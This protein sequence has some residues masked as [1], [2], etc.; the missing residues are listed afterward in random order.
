MADMAQR[1]ASLSPAQR[2]LLEQ[3][4]RAQPQV[5]QP[6]AVIGMSCRLPGASNPDEFWSLIHE[7][8]SAVTEIPAERWDANAFYDADYEALGKMATRWCAL[9]D[10][11]D[12]F[13]SLFFGIAPREAS[14]MDPQQRLLLESA[15]EA[16]E[17]A[18]IA[19]DQ[20]SGTTTGVFVGIGGTDYSKL[21]YQHANFYESI[22][23]HTGTGNALSIAANRVSY[24]LDLRGPSVAV[25]TACSSGLVALH[26]AVQALRSGECDA[27]L[28]GATNMILS[29]EVTI[30][31]SKARMLSPTGHCRPFD[32]EADGYVRGEGCAFVLLKR[33]TDAV[34]DGDNILGVIRGTAVNQDGRTSGITAPNSLSQEACI[35]TALAAAGLRPEDISYIEA[36]G[37]GT[38]LGDPIEFQSLAKLF[39]ATEPK[40]PTCFVTSVKANIGH[41]ETVSGIAGFIKVLLML[42]HGRIPKQAGL[43]QLN[44]SISLSG[45]RLQIP[46]QE[47]DWPSD[48]PRIAGISSFGFGGTNTH[49]VVESATPVQ[50]RAASDNPPPYH[51]LVISAKNRAALHDLAVLYRERL[52]SM[53]DDHLADFCYSANTGRT[54]FNHRLAMSADTRVTL[55]ERLTTAIEGKKHAQVHTGELRLAGRP[56]VA[57]LFTGQG[58]QYAGMGK[59]LYTH[60]PV[61]REIVDKC[62]AILAPVL[63]K[64][65]RE[66]MLEDPESLIDETAYT[67]PALFVIEYAL[68]KLWQSWGVEPTALL[69]H[70]VGE[71]VAACLAGVFSLEAGLLLIAKRATLMQAMPPNGMMAVIFAGRDQVEKVLEPYAARV[72]VAT[73][74]GPENNVISGST[75]LVEKAVAE[76]EKLGIGTQKLRVSHAF[77][78]P[79]MDPMLDEFEKFAEQFEF[80]RPRIPI[81]ANRT[82]RLTDTAEFNAAYWRDHLRNCVEFADGIA[83]L[84]EAGVDAFLEVGPAASLVGM[85]KR[86]APDSKALWLTSLR[87]NRDDF[88]TLLSA[89]CDLYVLG[90]RI[91]WSSFESPWAHHRLPLPNYPF[92]RSRHWYVGDGSGSVARGPSLHPLLGC[93]IGTALKSRIFEG[94]LSGD[95]PRYLRDHVVQ[96]GVVVPAAAYLEQ[97]LA[98]G[99]LTFGAGHHAVE[100]LAIQQGLFLPAEGARVVETVVGGESSGRAAFE[101][102]SAD[103][104]VDSGEAKW[105]LHGTGTIAHESTCKPEPLP[106]LPDRDAFRSAAIHVMSHDEIYEMF[107]TRALHYGPCFRV[108]SEVARNRDEA[109]ASLDLNEIVKAKLGDYTVHPAVGDAMLQLMAGVIPLEENLEHAPYTYIPMRVRSFQAFRPVEEQ[110]WL[111]ARRTSADT[112]HPETVEADVYLLTEDNQPV[113]AAR[114]VVVQRIGRSIQEGPAEES[115]HWLYEIAWREAEVQAANL[116][117]AAAQTAQDAVL[118]LGKMDG[119]GGQIA[120]VVR[121]AG[122]RALVAEPGKAFAGITTEQGI[123]RCQVSLIDDVAYAQLLDAAVDA[124]GNTW[125]VVHAFALDAPSLTTELQSVTDATDCGT[126]SALRLM[127]QLTRCRKIKRAHVCFLTRGGQQVQATDHVAVQQSALWGFGRVAAI[128]APDA[129]CRIMDLDPAADL[130][131][132]AMQVFHEISSSTEENQVAYRSG[133]RYVARLVEIADDIATVGEPGAMQVPDSANYRLRI[134][135]A[136]SFDGLYYEPFSVPEPP[137]GKVEIEVRA[138]GLNFSDV[139]KAMGLYPGITDA[140]VPLGIECA[141]IIRAVGKGVTRFKVGDEVMGVAPYSF[142]SRTVTADYALVH[143]P[144]TMDF[145]EAATIPITFLTAYYALV[146]LA[147]LQKGERVLIHAGAGGVGLAAIQIAQ[148]IGA[149]IF[150]TAGSEEKRDFVRSLGVPHVMSSRTLDF[151]DQIR[152]ITDRQGVDVVLNSLPGDFIDKSLEC[153]RAYGRFLE[154]GKTDI[155]SNTKIGLLPFQDNLSYFA[156]DLDRMLRQRG[157]YIQEM[158]IEMMKYFEDGRYRPLPFTQFATTDTVNAFR[159]MAQRKNIGKVVV[160]MQAARSPREEEAAGRALREDA[161][162]V[163]TGG[164]GALGLQVARQLVDDGARHIALLGRRAPS[165]E[166]RRAIEHAEKSGAKVAV[167]QGDVADRASLEAALRQIPTTFPDVRGIVHAA[168]V[169]ADGMMFD[170]D[171]PQWYQPLKPKIDGTW[172]LHEATKDLDLDFFVMFSSVAC[173]LG[174]PGQS[175]YAAGNAFL[176]GMV[177]YRQNQGLPATSINWGPWADSGMAAEAGRDSQLAGRGM[178]L[179]PSDKSLQLLSQF[180]ASRAPR[181]VVM[182]VDWAELVRAMG[183]K[184]S[185]LLREVASGAEGAGEEASA[186]DRAYRQTLLELPVA[187][188][189]EK[190]IGFF[191]QQMAQI[192][193]MEVADVDVISPLNSMGMDSLMAIELKNKI[194]RRLQT[195]LPMSVLIHEPSVTSLADYLSENLD[196]QADTAAVSVETKE[197]RKDEPTR[198]VGP[199]K[200][201]RV[202]AEK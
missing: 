155:Y 185:P 35:R 179:L 81:A 37:T 62:D 26:Y 19:P 84:E 10:H 55:I 25:D 29:P 91:D 138:T 11:F 118:I 184:A 115:G 193:G 18:G 163:I 60:H 99:K 34:A 131:A 6:I 145:Q 56:R 117:Q 100:N 42:Q 30:A 43:R 140:I 186:E 21:R 93:E 102:F 148:Q 126:T 109:I 171:L 5:A 98:A 178:R 73:A 114:G 71:Y 41:T 160:D 121:Q 45:T 141:G 36:H 8:R 174:S 68:A 51:V 38:P 22:D 122:G 152:E 72:T 106:P 154:I 83:C 130:A 199:H 191:A 136:G 139:L 195:S 49:V 105:H 120:E 176:D 58:S 74:N 85:G 133:I 177:A 65:I 156:I 170:M 135:S 128:E 54:H 75:E 66:I 1:M 89:L 201:R 189:R 202:G 111:Y 124:M 39:Q 113:A 168:G 86:C 134:R 59:G 167:I 116:G 142:A 175:N 24:V 96:G 97:G 132:Q 52:E 28:A 61:F 13:D 23:A 164:L 158:F 127:Q 110:M 161:T 180:L 181:V 57:M 172:N 190:L 53:P 87:K 48:R 107:A 123:A 125:K 143:K 108:S 104:Q 112:P 47:V 15:W 129:A 159:Y 69:G 17:N 196:G 4:L 12:H 80:A 78:S 95:S 64:S 183:G 169:L 32:A 88:K 79:L 20:L 46:L 119:L 16:I 3:R 194:E 50:P 82:G 200:G 7:G 94:R 173:V 147:Q 157:D 77:H 14:R 44:P 33:L 150:A 92:Q 197:I 2:R 192:M 188:R 70:S 153:L 162:Y 182:N 63:N 166:A 137:A 198:V 101:V 40:A 90:T 9:V 144:K 76:F 187:D 151:A 146:R 27:A 103:A 165:A 149:E 67:Q 31:F